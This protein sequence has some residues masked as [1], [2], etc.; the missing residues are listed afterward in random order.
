MPVFKLTFCFAK[1]S[2]FY[3]INK[4]V[5]ITDLNLQLEN[6]LYW[7]YYDYPSFSY[8]FDFFSNSNNNL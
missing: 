7:N 2:N 4:Q 6:E 5:N 8:N 3:K 1:D